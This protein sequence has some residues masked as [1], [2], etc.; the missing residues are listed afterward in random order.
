[1]AAGT[2]DEEADE[3]LVVVDSGADR[4]IHCDASNQVLVVESIVDGRINFGLWRIEKVR[5][6]EVIADHRPGL[7]GTVRDR[8][9]HGSE[10]EINLVNVR[11]REGGNS[12]LGVWAEF[13]GALPVVEGDGRDQT[14]VTSQPFTAPMAL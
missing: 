14:T 1:L 6:T 11:G 3:R 4:I 12:A 2:E 8:L 10:I 9:V 7:I 13:H 5:R